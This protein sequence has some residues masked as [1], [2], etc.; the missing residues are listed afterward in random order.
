LD[1][2]KYRAFL[3]Y[4]HRDSAWA[5]WLH[6]SLEAY[7]PPKI[8]VG[9]VATRGV[10]P[11][12][13]APVFRDREELASATDLGTVINQALRESACQIVLCSPQAA[14][15]KW[16]NEEILAFKRLGRED[17]IF[18]LII[19][20]E[21]NATDLPG[22]AEQECFPPAL[23]YRLGV[24]GELSNVRTEPIAADARPGKD[25]KQRAK[26]KLIAGILGLGYDALRR[27]EQQRRSRRLFAVTCAALAGMVVTS[28][29]AAYALFQR[30]AAQR[31]TRRAEAEAETAKQ[32]TNFLIDLFR[33]SDPSE[34]R[35]NSV[36]AREMLDKGAARID[37][38]LAGQP[39]IQATLLDTVGTVYM[40]LGLYREARPLLDRAVQRRREFAVD[41]ET[42]SQS[43]GH[44]GELQTLQANFDAGERSYREAIRYQ[45]ALP[46]TLPNRA[47]LAKSLH[48]LG[49]L[50][51]REGRDLDA[52][53]NFRQ[54]LQLQRQVLGPDHG[55]IARTLQDLAKVMDD[56]GDLKGAIPVMR[57]ALAMQRRLNGSQPDPGLAE[58]IND[59]GQLLYEAGD[60]DAAAK[61]YVEAIAVKHRL[62]GEKHPEI[63]ITLGNLAR[64]LQNKGDLPGAEARFR[65]AL[66]ML[67]ETLGELHPDVAMELNNLAFVQYDRGDRRTALATER[68]ALDLLRELFPG[69]HPEVARLENRIGF[70]LTEAGDYT[71]ADHDLEDALAMRRRLLGPQHPD[72]AGS[73]DHLAILQVARGQNADALLSARNAVSIFSSALSPTHWKTAVGECAEAAALTGLGR[74]AEAEPL[75]QHGLAILDKDPDA[76][77]AYRGLA[78][79]YLERLNAAQ[80]RRLRARAAADPPVQPAAAVATVP[81]SA[82]LQQL[83]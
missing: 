40:G 16:V 5:S 18:C 79:H 63:A 3:S 13:L 50:L 56:R 82:S 14:K 72:V 37:H 41:P 8:L 60:Y 17:S 32:T 70:W 76:P 4:S 33:I 21:P 52:E 66:A 42:L 48:G 29:L 30:S 55:D 43:L 59:T 80:S 22:A 20:G 81:A 58:A 53:Q 44:L 77:E 73:L 12:R 9:T 10:V 71:E 45:S 38:D 49:V 11:R 47:A 15:S 64:A 6:K 25:G 51:A 26:L 46:A 36:T 39:A 65:E 27:R 62:L 24:D 61:L 68:Q 35:G 31:Q 75:L 57:Q 74:Y 69:D 7:R 1:Q 78:Q 2:F 54:A 23:R 28:G 34:A 67:R 83:P 19:G